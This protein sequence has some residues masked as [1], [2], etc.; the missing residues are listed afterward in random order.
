MDL[1]K[2]AIIAIAVII[3]AA[4]VIIAAGG[5]FGSSV[6]VEGV[7]LAIPS[8][9]N[10]VTSADDSQIKWFMKEEKEEYEGFDVNTTVFE[11]D[12]PD[13]EHPGMAVFPHY[14][15]ISTISS[16]HDLTLDDVING[17]DLENKTINGKTGLFNSSFSDTFYFV[18]NGKLIK[19][20]LVSVEDVK[21]EDIIPKE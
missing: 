12:D 2:I 19:I 16:S 8:G 9:Y 18:E 15:I 1:K 6:D 17:T 7:K 21:L 3:V 4:V 14:I 10:D 5:L 20:S 13:P 11:K